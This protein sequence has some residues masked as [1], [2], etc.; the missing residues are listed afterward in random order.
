MNDTSLVRILRTIANDSST[1]DAQSDFQDLLDLSAELFKCVGAGLAFGCTPYFSVPPSHRHASHLC[2]CFHRLS[3]VDLGEEYFPKW[4]LFITIAGDQL[5]ET[6][7]V[8]YVRMVR[9]SRTA[10]MWRSVPARPA[11]R[12][13][14]LQESRCRQ[15]PRL[16]ATLFNGPL[17]HAHVASAHSLPPP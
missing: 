2:R 11:C 5:N 16:F 7:Y 10:H 12:V 4:E 13:S 9:L 6:C 17:A 8:P 3:S 15:E 14:S 1:P